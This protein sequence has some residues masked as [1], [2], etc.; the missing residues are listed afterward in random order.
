VTGKNKDF[1]SLKEFIDK[2]IVSSI[3]K[4]D[5]G[6]LYEPSKYILQTGGKR[7]R[8]ILV[9][10]T[11]ELMNVKH[12]SSINY[13]AAIEIL[14]LFTLVH[15]DIMDN[16]TLRRGFETIHNR[17]DNGTA[18]LSGDF[19][20]G[21]AYNLLLKSKSEQIDK[22]AQV[23]TEAIIEVC[24]GQAYDKEFETRNDINLNEYYRMIEKKT[25]KL[26]ITSCLLGG[27]I[28]NASK[29]ELSALKKYG[30]YIGRA[31]Q[32]VDDLLDVTSTE[33]KLGKNIYNDIKENKK[34]YFYA[35]A[36]DIFSVKD[37]SKLKKLYSLKE[38]DKNA[39]NEVV[40]LYRKYNLIDKAEHEV[41]NLIKKAKQLLLIFPEQKRNNLD[42]FTN[43]LGLRK[44]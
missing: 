24:E 30:F 42:R 32:I 43:T 10:L 1:S 16:A 37:I 41:I 11:G 3:K 34:T 12:S 17:W 21:L 29:K 28:G 25:G 20:V 22:I 27:L 31:F 7:I 26:F 44:F 9:L 36:L 14:H 35:V 39:I 23:F 6:L 33:E 4:N 19:L 5:P 40:E 15:D 18:I 38:K 2:R 8:G 13:A